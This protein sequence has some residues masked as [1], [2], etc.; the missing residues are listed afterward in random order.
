MLKQIFGF[1]FIL[2]ATTNIQSQDIRGS[3]IKY[4]NPTN[5]TCN[6]EISLYVQ[7]G[8][9]IDR[10]TMMFENTIVP[11]ISTQL[12]NNITLWKYSYQYAFSGNGTHQIYYPDSFRISSIS[13]IM[14]SESE[15]ILPSIRLMMNPYIGSNSSPVFLNKQ[16]DIYRSG[17][18][19]IHEPMAFDA[20]GDSLVFSLAPAT[21]SNYTFPT[22]ISIDSQTGKVELPYS[23]NIY[24]I[25]IRIDEFRNGVSVSSTNREMLIDG[26]ALINTISENSNSVKFDLFPNPVYQLLNV[27]T[28]ANIDDDF[29]IF[30]DL[31]RI[32]SSGK[33]NGGEAQIDLS[34]IAQGVYF[35]IVSQQEN[36]YR[37][38]FVKI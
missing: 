18:T 38:R 30:D 35:F 37:V 33:I 8:M 32:V 5:Q 15:I 6:F 23:S 12:S 29:Q 25:N 2:L 31:G 14:N 9:G 20:E 17:N 3:E 22:G 26:N 21:S 7:S 4:N 34:L 28:E 16:T 1:L 27:K 13:N 19:I 24:A 10:D 11:G 36:I